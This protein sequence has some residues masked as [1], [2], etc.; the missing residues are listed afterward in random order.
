MLGR[1]SSLTTP[2]PLPR[3]SVVEGSDE[4]LFGSSNS[5]SRKGN[6]EGEAGEEMELIYLLPLRSKFDSEALAERKG[7]GAGRGVWGGRS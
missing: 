2:L 3:S 5:I 1:S 4:W 7:G 6:D